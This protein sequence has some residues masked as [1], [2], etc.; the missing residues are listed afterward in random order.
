M[1]NQDEF[2]KIEGVAAD[3]RR[4]Q[5][6]DDLQSEMRGDEVGRISRFLSPETRALLVGNRSGNQSS[7][8]TALDLVLLN[9]RYYA[10]IYGNAMEKLANYEDATEVALI[11]VEAKLTA[12]ETK[13]VNTLDNAATLPDGRKV[14]RNA[15]GQVWDRHNNQ[16]G[17]AAASSVEWTGSEPSYETYLEQKKTVQDLKASS[18]EI[19][20]YQTDT[21]GRLREKLTNPNQPMSADEIEAEMEDAEARMPEAVKAEV[22]E[23]NAAPLIKA[24][25][26][27]DVD[28]PDLS[29]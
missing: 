15:A 8:M 24:T 9:D 14:F 22:S 29:S 4:I 25:Q 20:T 19:R 28:V 7:M 18:L 6:F 5:D 21:L 2:D 13:L 27:F 23:N 10:E 16:I 3:R 26:S 1:D 12:A 11:K 17:D